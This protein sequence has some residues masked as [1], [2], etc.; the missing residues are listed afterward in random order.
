M[1]YVAYRTKKGVLFIVR[2]DNKYFLIE[3]DMVVKIKESVAQL[4]IS[5]NKIIAKGVVTS[6]IASEKSVA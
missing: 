3:R 4:I 6:F 5:S 2:S 1:N